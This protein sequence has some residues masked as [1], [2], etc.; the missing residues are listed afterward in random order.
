MIKTRANPW[1]LRVMFEAMTQTFSVGM[2]LRGL[3][4]V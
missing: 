2:S 4:S 3:K 1:A